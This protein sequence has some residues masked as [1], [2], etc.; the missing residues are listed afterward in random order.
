MLGVCHFLQIHRKV[1]RTFGTNA[2]KTTF[3]HAA[4]PYYILKAKN[5]LVIYLCYNTESNISK[6]L[7]YSNA[8]KTY[9]HANIR[10]HYT[11]FWHRTPVIIHVNTTPN[12]CISCPYLHP[13]FYKVFHTVQYAGYGNILPLFCLSHTINVIPLWHVVL[14]GYLLRKF[15][16]I[17]PSEST[18]L[19]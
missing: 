3:T 5:A 18:I 4:K 15:L 11:V 7:F 1:G 8:L 9:L 17:T 14:L 19:R 2:N 13:V 10:L 12:V 16:F 6:T